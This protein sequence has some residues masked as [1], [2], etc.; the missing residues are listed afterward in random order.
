MTEPRAARTL[1]YPGLSD[2]RW[3]Q[4]AFLVCFVSYALASPGFSR[5]PIQW[6]VGIAT[7]VGLDFLLTL[8]LRGTLVVPVS[9]L[10]SSMGLLLL[11]DSPVLWPYPAC[12]ALAIGSKH[13]IRFRGK[14]V[15]NPLNFGIVVGLL[16]FSCDMTIV[17]SRW[18]GGLPAMAFVAILGSVASY[19]AH[20]LDLSAT[21]VVTFALGGIV[22]MLI[23]HAPLWT[24][25][26]PMTGAAFQLFTFF[27]ISDPMT[28][29][30][31]SRGRIVYGVV[32]ASLDS[33]LRFNQIEFSP[34]FAL[35]LMAGLL[36]VFRRFF[37]PRE[38]EVVWRPVV[39]ELGPG[40]EHATK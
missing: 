40:L 27:M 36:P 39:R 32:L 17:A 9:G 28:T 11:C 20:R 8:L 22:R 38:E 5:S 10:I 23:S 6:L 7:C 29:P 26:N 31:T 24:V 19:K 15:F 30:Q 21:Y 37:A 14:H 16:L 1:I 18:G 34:F 3:W 2:P 25:L 12:G 4:L 35:F 13:I 33:V